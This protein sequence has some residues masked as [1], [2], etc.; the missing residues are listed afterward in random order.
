[1]RPFWAL[2]RKEVH[3][4]RWT[5][6]LSTLALFG[7][8]WLFVYVTSL[9]EAEIVRQLGSDSGDIGGRIRFLR[10]LGIEEEPRSV[11]L[12]MASWNHP[13]ILIVISVWAIGRGSGAVAAEIERGTLD[14]ILSRPVARWVYLTAHICVA[15]AGLAILG[16]ALMG[17]AAMALR[18]NVLRQPPGAWTLLQ[19]AINLAALGLPIYGYTLLASAV[20]HVR[21]RPASVGAVLT[22]AGFIAWVIALIPVLRDTWWRPWLERVSIFKAYNPVELVTK[23]QTLGVNLAILGSL[24]AACITLAFLAFALRDLPANG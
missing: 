19:P 21:R 7:L 10:S 18:Y 13:F 8:G 22:L 4:S 9:N 2:I 3:E 1:M 20:D 16:L 5:L 14:L 17:G 6:V 23:G 11:A 24:G 15:V 12:I